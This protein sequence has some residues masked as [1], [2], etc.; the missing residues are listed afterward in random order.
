[1]TNPL[2]RTGTVLLTQRSRQRAALTAALGAAGFTVFERP[3]IEVERSTLAPAAT[4]SMPT[5]LIFVSPAAAEHGVPQLPPTWRELPRLAVGA[6]T[7]EALTEVGWP[8]TPSPASE[9][10]E[11]LLAL[12]VLATVAG[13]QIAIVRGDGGRELLADTLRQRGADVRYLEVYR[14]C[15]L[16]PD[17]VEELR[18]FTANPLTVVLSSVE[19][20]SRLCAI[21]P[22]D[23]LRALTLVV[24]STRIAEQAAGLLQAQ[25][26][27]T[28]P[29]HAHS[30]STGQLPA[31]VLAAS[32]GTDDL[33]AAITRIGVN[34]S[35]TRQAS[36]DRQG[37]P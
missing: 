1:M 11:G 37:N 3:L 12:P 24:T 21:I 26:L 9:N 6:A 35:T 5:R 18:A 36:T 4:Q 10:S 17:Q 7:A 16:K 31:I 22:A 34:V 2:T 14:K 23:R 8:Q 29:L 32:A 15:P 28:D 19:A 25:A 27:P 20:L 33:L 30:L 13:E